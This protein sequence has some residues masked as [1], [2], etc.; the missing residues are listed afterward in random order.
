MPSKARRGT[1]NGKG[2]ARFVTSHSRRN[3]GCLVPRPPQY[4]RVRSEECLGTTTSDC[5]ARLRGKRQMLI[6]RHRPFPALPKT[7]PAART[8]FPCSQ[9]ARQTVIGAEPPHGQGISPHRIHPR[10][11]KIP[12]F[13]PVNRELQLRP[14]VMGLVPLPTTWSCFKCT[15]E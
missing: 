7:F 4:S 2:A 3:P 6:A 15:P 8:N 11:L 10:C 12:E 9:H 14:F 13:F 1:S 5:A